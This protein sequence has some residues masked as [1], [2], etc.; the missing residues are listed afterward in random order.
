MPFRI[1][2]LRV[3]VLPSF[4]STVMLYVPGVRVIWAGVV[5]G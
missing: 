3:A 1:S 2:T 4:H 5:C